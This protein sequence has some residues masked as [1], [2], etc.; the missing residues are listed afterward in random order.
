M[1]KL[2]PAECFL[3][4]TEW[5]GRQIWKRSI[6][7]IK[8]KGISTPSPVPLNANYLFLRSHKLIVFKLKSSGMLLIPSEDYWFPGGTLVFVLGVS[9]CIMKDGELTQNMP[10]FEPCM[11]PET[12][13]RRIFSIES[14]AQCKDILLLNGI[15]YSLKKPQTNKQFFFSS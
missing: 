10:N 12:H 4:W 6:P 3:S 13:K 5:F 14:F 15:I 7:H 9:R 1:I 11:N 2:C 8:K